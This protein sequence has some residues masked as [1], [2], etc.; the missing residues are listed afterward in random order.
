MSE[1]PSF[2][3]SLDKPVYVPFS[4][5]VFLPNE[6]TKEHL[7]YILG[8]L[9][10]KLLWGWYKH[11]AKRRGVGL[12]INGNVLSRSPIRRINFDDRTDLELHDRLVSIVDH[13]ID[14]QNRKVA[15]ADAGE[16]ERIQ[17]LI[18]ATDKQIDILVYELFRLSPEEIGLIE[19]DV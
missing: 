17:R 12:E 5:N 1:R 9:N 8:I 2:T 19:R 10:S 18:D 15:A 11:E 13:M 7:F 14:L 4:V 3:V 16:Q 6:T